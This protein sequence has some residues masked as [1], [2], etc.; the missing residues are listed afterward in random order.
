MISNRIFKRS[1]L[2][3]ILIF[4]LAA[5]CFAQDPHT[6]RLRNDSLL[7]EIHPG[8]FALSFIDREGIRYPVSAGRQKEQA[9]NI[10]SD[11]LHAQ[12][13]LAGTGN[14]VRIDLKN[15]YLEVTIRA[16]EASVFTWPE[17]LPATPAGA[18]SRTG[19]SSGPDAFTIPL[20]EGKYIPARD[21]QW[22]DYLSHHGPYSGLQDFSMQFFAADFGRRSV[23]YIIEN[24]FNNELEF[25]NR[26]GALGLRFRHEFPATVKYKQ[27][28]FRIYLTR[29]NT[30]TIAKTYRNYILEKGRFTTLEEKAAKNPNIR[31]LYGAPFI[32]IWNSAFL[33]SDD[34]TD[35]SAFRE[36]LVKESGAVT[37]NPTKYILGLFKT[38]QWGQEFLKQWNDFAKG[39]WIIHYHRDLFAKALDE[40]MH[41][42]EFA[43]GEVWKGLSLDEES[44]QLINDAGHL[45]VSASYRLNELLLYRAYS[46]FLR[47][48]SDW[49]GAPLSLL[50]ELKSAGIKNAWLGMSDDWVQGEVHLDFVRKA[51]DM[52]YLIGPYDSYHSMHVPGKEK[53]LTAKFDDTTLYQRAYVMKK[54]GQ[55]STGFLGLGRHLNPML[56][57]PAVED[58]LRKIMKATD[59]QFNSWFIDCDATGEFFD[60]YTPGRMTNQQQDLEARLQRMAW[61]RDTYNLVIGSEDGND[62]A[63]QTL[64]FGHGMVTPVVEWNDPDLRTNKQSPY[65]LG[66]YFSN[67]GGIPP[68]YVK[69]VPVKKKYQYIYF[70]NRFNVPLFQLVYN[71]SEITTHHWEWGSL[72]APGEIINTELKEILYNVPPLYHLDKKYWALFKDEISKQIRVFSTTHPIAI[73]QEMT[74]FS[75]ISQDRMVQMTRF[76]NVLEIVANFGPQPF[77]YSGKVIPE[78]GLLIHHLDTGAYAVYKP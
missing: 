42:L 2:S 32:Y 27:Y 67:S 72:K 26:G 37:D 15:D 7:V 66:G 35:W 60:D 69:Q 53:W 9:G 8:S 43:N 30:V 23:L 47:P 51:R 78:H 75:W 76:G 52:G 68:R 13:D 65:F 18:S 12:W 57:F 64:A 31:K 74:D 5:A 29:N 40:A 70:D 62:F 10:Q 59:G 24:S 17:I 4:R 61:I 22:V 54:N 38:G 25:N 41:S 6:I 19:V 34:V 20:H 73:R 55:P 49:G 16:S 63:S 33:G 1:F 39:P 77:T 36:Y 48:I 56:V 71:N 50:D 11:A 46:R 21:P 3:A 45:T 28:G 14:S 44:R 58:R